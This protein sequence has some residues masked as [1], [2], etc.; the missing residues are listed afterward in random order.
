MVRCGA[1]AEII[2]P[3]VRRAWSLP[4]E[5]YTSEAWLARVRDKAFARSWHFVADESRVSTPGRVVPL[6]L[7]DGC[8]DEPI[9]LARDGDALRCFSNVC[10]HR[11]NLVV[12]R[13]GDVRMLEG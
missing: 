13:E 12:E 8:L 6:A 3:D 5:A 4:G 9:V 10:T 11:G 1:M 2:D 7:L